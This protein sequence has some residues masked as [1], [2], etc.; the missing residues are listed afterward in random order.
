ME[1]TK[2]EDAKDFYNLIEH[3]ARERQ[4]VETERRQKLKEIFN[5]SEGNP[6]DRIKKENL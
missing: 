3:E 5:R 6:F 1:E 2:K 4:R